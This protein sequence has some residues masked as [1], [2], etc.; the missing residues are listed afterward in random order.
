MFLE[1]NFEREAFNNAFDKSKS[2]KPQVRAGECTQASA[3]YRVMSSDGQAWY[4]VEFIRSM[5]GKPFGSCSCAAGRDEL[6]CYHLAAAL[7]VHCALV[8]H[9]IRPSISQSV[10][11]HG[12][13]A[14]ATAAT[15]PA[16]A[17]LVN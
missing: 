12:S 2:V 3:Q 6:Y 5:S 9:G 8:R 1:I 17:T 16:A 11:A 13:A 7:Y 4:N 10:W 14:A 15:A